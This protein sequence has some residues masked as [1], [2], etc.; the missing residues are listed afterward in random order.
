[1]WAHVSCM[2]NK[3]KVSSITPGQIQLRILLKFPLFLLP[4]DM[5]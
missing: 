5:T 1:M 3:E 4:D 2:E